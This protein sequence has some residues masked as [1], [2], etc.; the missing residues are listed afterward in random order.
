MWLGQA[1]EQQQPPQPLL[2]YFALSRPRCL[3]AGRAGNLSLAAPSPGGRRG[4]AKDLT[5]TPA[6]AAAAVAIDNATAAA[7]PGKPLN[8][9]FLSVEMHRATLLRRVP[10]PPLCSA[11]RRYYCVRFMP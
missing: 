11:A 6:A 1:K 5:S 10:A 7:T 4:V 2:L 9:H 8:S 3:D